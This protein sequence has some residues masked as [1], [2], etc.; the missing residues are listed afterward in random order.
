MAVAVLVEVEVPDEVEM[1][2]AI[3]DEVGDEDECDVE[4]EVNVKVEF[5]AN[6]NLKCKP[7]TTALETMPEAPTVQWTT[8]H[9]L[10]KYCLPAYQKSGLRWGSPAITPL[11]HSA[12]L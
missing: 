6:V 7:F 9:H 2:D 11:Y 12:R 3:E 8:Y 5:V 4:V 10:S 1:K